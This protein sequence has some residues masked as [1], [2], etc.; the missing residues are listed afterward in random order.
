MAIIYMPSVDLNSGK[1]VGLIVH[2]KWIETCQLMAKIIAINTGSEVSWDNEP[3]FISIPEGY[4]LSE[5]QIQE[6]IKS[7]VRIDLIRRHS[8][9]DDM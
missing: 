4:V 2:N 9:K 6:L 7:R 5:K 8:L 3:K 1:D